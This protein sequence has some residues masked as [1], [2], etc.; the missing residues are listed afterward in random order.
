MTF[1]SIPDDFNDRHDLDDCSRSARLL[2][3]ELYVYANL[4]GRDGRIPIGKLRRITD[5][6]DPERD[7]KELLENDR[8]VRMD[9]NVIVLDWTHQRTAARLEELAAAGRERKARYNAKKEKR[10]KAH[11]A[12]DHNLCDPDYCTTLAGTR[13][14]TRDGTAPLPDPTTTSTT[15]RP[16]GRGSGGGG[17]ANAAP[18]PLGMVEP[19][20]FVDD[21]T[22]PD[23]EACGLPSRNR[24]HNAPQ[25]LGVS[26]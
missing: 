4:T 16:I 26:A 17:S 3:V 20:D 15:T 23:C 8:D 12:G 14:R 19:H 1:T 5:S 18:P 7:L 6:D 10:E 25:G 24:K 11:A 21:G 9:G 13:S 2:H 22:G